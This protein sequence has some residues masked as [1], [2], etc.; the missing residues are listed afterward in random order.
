MPF[1]APNGFK[2]LKKAKAIWAASASHVPF[3]NG[4]KARRRQASEGLW[5]KGMALLQTDR[6]A[7]QL[8]LRT[9]LAQGADITFL[10][11]NQLLWPPQPEAMEALLHHAP[12]LRP[13]SGWS[14]RSNHT[15]DTL[16]HFWAQAPEPV[17][18]NTPQVQAMTRLLWHPPQ[19]GD[20]EGAWPNSLLSPYLRALDVDWW[21]NREGLTPRML[22]AA[23][24]HWPL[25]EAFAW[26]LANVDPATELVDEDKQGEH[27]V[28]HWTNG[29]L[30]RGEHLTRP[31]KS[32]TAALKSEDFPRLLVKSNSAQGTPATRLWASGVTLAT[33]LTWVKPLGEQGHKA[34]AKALAPYAEIK[35]EDG[36]SV[37]L[38]E[39]VPAHHGLDEM[40]QW[41]AM[42]TSKQP[43]EFIR[44]P[45]RKTSEVPASILSSWPPALLLE[46]LERHWLDPFNLS[47]QANR[48][49]KELLQK[50]FDRQEPWFSALLL[51]IETNYPEVYHREERYAQWRKAVDLDTALPV[52]DEGTKRT[53]F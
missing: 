12:S 19:Q 51:L 32:E 44:A 47:L 5:E 11:A 53:R 2:T 30:A 25:V 6:E 4:W 3:T 21:G 20:D 8:T 46:A 52:A 14:A 33:L 28:D 39:H 10:K 9:A 31:G 48:G 50:A 18:D 40:R 27:W 49:W 43:I 41:A 35:R 13:N 34:L 29:L 42:L 37:A 17:H 16:L 24:G 22:A 7:A 26:P 38:V 23:H 36:T 45:L 15:R 1:R